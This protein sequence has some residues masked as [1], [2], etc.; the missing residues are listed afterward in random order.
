MRPELDGVFVAL[1]GLI[2]LDLI[3]AVAVPGELKQGR[4]DVDVTFRRIRIDADDLS[5]LRQ[6]LLEIA[7]TLQRKA[8][9][10]IDAPGVPIQ[11][12]RL[13]ELLLGLAV[14]RV[15]REVVSPERI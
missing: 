13:A 8:Q 1:P 6:G 11:A 2:E 7:L 15:L 3:H 9:P 12:D 5:K 4:A 10:V 14:I